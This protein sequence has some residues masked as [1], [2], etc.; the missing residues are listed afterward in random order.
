MASNLGYDARQA[1]QQQQP[2]QP[3]SAHPEQPRPEQPRPEQPRPEQPRPQAEWPQAGRPQGRQQGRQQQHLPGIDP[4]I[5]PLIH[6]SAARLSWNQ[7]GFVEQLHYDV[8]GLTGD[9]AAGLAPS[10]WTFCERMVHSLLWVALTDQPVP[11]IVDT[12]YQVGAQNW[13]EGFSEAHYANFAHALVQTVH[14]LSDSDWSAST[15]SAWI[16]YFLWTKSH[17]LAGAQ[18]AATQHAATQQAEEIQAAAV[19]AAAEQ[20]AARVA[21]LARDTPVVGDVNLESVAKLL[22]DDEDDEEDP[23]YGHIMLGMTRPPKKDPR[24][25][26]HE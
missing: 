12:L 9:R 3:Q 24:A 14:Y 1:A 21:A 23:G 5:W 22:N 19:R 16:S 25:S 2:P 20:E 13:S 26:S 7:E 18:Y 4:G 17:L 6:A 11:V 15:G 10:M 8:T